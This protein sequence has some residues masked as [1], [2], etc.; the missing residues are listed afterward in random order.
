MI[1][2]NKENVIKNITSF[3]QFQRK[4]GFGYYQPGVAEQTG[5]T[6]SQLSNYE[7]GKMIPSL[8]AAIA[9]AD[10]FDISLDYLVGRCENRNA[11]KTKKEPIKYKED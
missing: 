9:I 5:I 6:Q 10:C 7:K 4:R 1:K 3:L 8:L 2:T 11:H